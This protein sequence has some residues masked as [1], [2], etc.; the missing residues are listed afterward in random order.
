MKKIIEYFDEEA[1]RHD[2]YFMRKLGM[3][4]FYDEIEYQINQCCPIKNLLVIG[5]GTGLEI[6]RIKFPCNV[7]AV[8]ISP[9]MIQQLMRKKY[10]QGVKVT[11]VCA[12]ILDYDLGKEKYD[13]VI[14]CY[15]LH[16]FNEQQKFDII[17][18]V[19]CCLKKKGV[20]INGDSTAHN[21]YD[22]LER[23]KDAEQIYKQENMP[24]ASL[25]IDVPLTKEKEISIL[26]LVGFS[27]IA[28]EKEWS[29]TTL[30]KCVK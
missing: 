28:I 18:K 14:T 21:I 9:V 27:S 30:Y 13:V 12:S 23:I 17:T 5:C 15:T 29:E 7:T 3:T 6:E 26:E 11:P 4:E 10:Y 25:H 2:N 8:D 20:F 22:E 16:H 1:V 24:F 19:F